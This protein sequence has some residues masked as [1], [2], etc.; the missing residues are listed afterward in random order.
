LLDK[1][2]GD[3]LG[4]FPGSDALRKQAG[5]LNRHCHCNRRACVSSGNQE[6]RAEKM[7]CTVCDVALEQTLSRIPLDTTMTIPV[8]TPRAAHAPSV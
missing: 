6:L 5:S 7:L 8:L 3:I 4:D 1:T 2:P